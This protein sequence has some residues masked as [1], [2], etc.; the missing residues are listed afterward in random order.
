MKNVENVVKED[1]KSK[2]KKDIIEA[3]KELF[4]NK[5]LYLTTMS[6]IAQE[7]GITRRTLYRY[8]KTKEEL[9]FEIE[10]LLF[11]DLY[12]FQNK[13][14]QNLNGT[15]IEKLEVFLEEM[16]NYVKKNSNI[17]KFSGVFDYYFK[18]EYP[19]QIQTQRFLSMI[20]SNDYLLEKIIEDGINDGSMR[21]DLDCKLTGLTISNVLL[22]L[23]QRIL[24]REDHL[25]VEQGIVSRK[26]IDHQVKLFIYALKSK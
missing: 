3:A 15:G 8:F 2:R 23:S 1:T 17:I 11:S 24:M 9:A 26:M 19:N 13:I 6:D 21:S 22:S 18:K 20:S 4:I 14:Y 7:I 25:D 12:N 10:I 16:L 5:G